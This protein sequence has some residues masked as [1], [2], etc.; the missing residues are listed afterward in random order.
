MAA[1][2]QALKMGDLTWRGRSGQIPAP[3]HIPCL[4]GSKAAGVGEQAR[5]RSAGFEDRGSA[6]GEGC[7]QSA[8]LQD[9]LGI[10]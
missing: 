8:W 7:H 9:F 2:S 5:G 4:P 10:L 1:E 3:V 6:G